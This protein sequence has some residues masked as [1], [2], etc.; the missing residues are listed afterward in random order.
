MGS[1]NC[2][3]L[4]KSDIVS[5][6]RLEYRF[7]SLIVTSVIGYILLSE[8]SLTDSHLHHRSSNKVDGRK[9]I[10]KHFLSSGIVFL[11]SVVSLLDISNCSATLL[12]Q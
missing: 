3:F 8:I 9:Y 2:C 1:R 4:A 11:L 7:L 10:S 6:S 5:L 12:L